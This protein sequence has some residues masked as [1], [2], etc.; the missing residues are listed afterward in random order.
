MT[1]GLRRRPIY[2]CRVEVSLRVITRRSRYI[3]LNKVFMACRQCD[4]LGDLWRGACGIVVGNGDVVGAGVPGCTVAKGPA[5]SRAGKG[6]VGDE[7]AA[8]DGRGGLRCE[9]S[10]AC[11]G[12]DE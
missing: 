8:D 5:G 4:I 9:R 2:I 10:V 3:E 7:L 12:G 6:A 1:V 11:G